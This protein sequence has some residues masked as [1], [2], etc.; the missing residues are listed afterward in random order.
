MPS[1]LPA[2][3]AVLRNTRGERHAVSTAIMLAGFI[4]SDHAPAEMLFAL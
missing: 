4:I 2:G 3:N 1:T